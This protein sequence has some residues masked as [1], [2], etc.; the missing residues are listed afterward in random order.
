ML[1][2][3]GLKRSIKKPPRSLQIVSDETADLDE[4]PPSVVAELNNCITLDMDLAG[5][6][7]LRP[8]SIG[9]CYREGYYVMRNAR[10]EPQ[11]LPNKLTL[12]LGN[13]NKVHDLLQDWLSRSN[14]FYMPKEVHI[15]RP[16]LDIFGH[17]DN[18]AIRRSDM[19]RFVIELKSINNAGFNRLTQPKDSHKVQANLYTGLLRLKWFVVVYYNKDNSTLREFK[20]P[21]SQKMFN[22]SLAWCETVKEAAAA[23]ELPKFSKDTCNEDFC[24]FVARCK[25]DGRK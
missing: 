12:I 8:S 3:S 25:K 21:F 14:N 18:V 7:F 23:E 19:Y 4:E 16:D 15:W 9:G 11:H 5:K 17:I 2:L 22:Q 1:R 13:G 20:V 10:K 6:K 24:R